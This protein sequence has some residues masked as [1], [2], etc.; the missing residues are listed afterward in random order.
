MVPLQKTFRDANYRPVNPI[1]ALKV[2]TPITKTPLRVYKFYI[3]S[4]ISITYV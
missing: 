4:S 2:D 1:F 3:V